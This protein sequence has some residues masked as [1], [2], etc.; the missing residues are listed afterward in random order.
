MTIECLFVLGPDKVE[1]SSVIYTLCTTNPVVGWWK[2][3]TVRNNA[4]ASHQLS[5]LLQRESHGYE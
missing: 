4:Q 2:K 1:E 3:N 5:H